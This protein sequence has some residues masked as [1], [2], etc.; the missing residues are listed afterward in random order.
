MTGDRSYQGDRFFLLTQNHHTMEQQQRITLSP[1][2]TLAGWL[3]TKVRAGHGGTQQECEMVAA[4][5][6]HQN[7]LLQEKLPFLWQWDEKPSLLYLRFVDES[8]LD[9]EQAVEFLNQVGQNPQAYKSLIKPRPLDEI[10]ADVERRRRRGNVEIEEDEVATQTRLQKEF[11]LIQRAIGGRLSYNDLTKLV[12]LDGQVFDPCTAKITLNIDYG[13]PIRSAKDE[14]ADIILRLARGNRIN[15]I[16][17]YVDKCQ[18]HVDLEE[19]AAR[20]FGTSQP[21]HGQY[22]RRWLIAAVARAYKPGCKVDDVLI[23][24]GKQGI[25]KSTFF[26][27]IVPDPDWFDDSFGNASDKDERLKLHGVWVVEWAEL[28][29]VIRRKGVAA[30]KSFLSSSTDRLRPPYSRAM[31]VLHRPSLIVGTTN[32]SEFLGDTTGNRRFWVIPVSERLPIK[33]IEENRDAIWA[34][35]RD[36]Y[37]SGEPWWFS[38]EETAYIENLNASY[39]LDDVWADSVSGYLETRE[40]TT[41]AEILAQCIDMPLERQDQRSKLRVAA[42]LQSLGFQK[43]SRKKAIGGGRSNVWV[44]PSLDKET[45][46]TGIIDKGSTSSPLVEPLSDDPSLSSQ[47]Q[48]SLSGTGTQM[49]QSKSKNRLGH[50]DLK[51][52]TTSGKDLRADVPVSQSSLHFFKSGQKLEKQVVAVKANAT[53]FRLGS[54]SLPKRSQPRSLQKAESIKIELLDTD[55]FAELIGDSE[56]LG[57][58]DDRQRVRLRSLETGRVSVFDAESLVVISEGVSH[59]NG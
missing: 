42:I 4:T 51:P 24:Q 59:A 48:K 45:G 37:K 43:V 32:E 44:L 34:T 11:S 16:T 6:V 33:W 38:P 53:W 20:L 9:M 1:I 12:Y 5:L 36:L 10:T 23:L 35:A 28:E 54:D 29:N 25:G 27:S 41:I 3:R 22:L 39:V 15:P 13:L 58:S 49:S 56:L 26:K 7:I 19:L 2:S 18:G 14:V 31:E 40:E 17:A 52:E 55:A 21:L 30:V 47:P 46:T 57:Y 8:K 50:Y